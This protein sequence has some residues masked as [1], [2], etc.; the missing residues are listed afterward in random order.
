M[1]LIEINVG[2]NGNDE[3]KSHLCMVISEISVILINVGETSLV[4]TIKF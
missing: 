4:E 1:E 2:N 3:V